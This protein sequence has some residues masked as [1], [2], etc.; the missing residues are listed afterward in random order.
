MVISKQQVPNVWKRVTCG[1][2]LSEEDL[3]V[4]GRL[5]AFRG[6]QYYPDVALL[7]LTSAKKAGSLSAER[8]THVLNMN[9]SADFGQ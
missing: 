6:E 7:L 4:G 3:G 2:K 5:P 1:H 9:T 8:P